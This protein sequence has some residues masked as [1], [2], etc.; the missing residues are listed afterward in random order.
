LSGFYI[1]F[2]VSTRQL[3]FPGKQFRALEEDEILFLDAVREEQQKKERSRQD[4]DS[5]EVD[6]FK[7]CAANFQAHEKNTDVPHR[8]VAAREQAKHSPPSIGSSSSPVNVGMPQG[9][10]S[11]ASSLSLPPKQKPTIGKKDQ[12]TLLKG[13]VKKKPANARPPQTGLAGPPKPASEDS[14]ATS[15]PTRKRTLEDSTPAKSVPPAMPV[16]SSQSKRIKTDETANPL[17]SQRAL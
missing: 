1:S 8:A 16:E 15:T 17:A 4:K 13:I 12:K 2:E 5:E 7:Q 10:G 3:T 11:A 6:A 14:A 9:S